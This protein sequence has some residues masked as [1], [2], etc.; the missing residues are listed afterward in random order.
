MAGGVVLASEATPFSHISGDNTA[1][2]ILVPLTNPLTIQPGTSSVI[3][4][5]ADVAPSIT[6]AFTFALANSTTAI[7]ATG[8]STGKDASYSSGSALPG[9]TQTISAMGITPTWTAFSGTDNAFAN[10]VGHVAGTLTLATN[11]SESDTVNQISVDA[12]TVANIRNM[13][14][15]D[16]NGNVLTNTITAPIASPNVLVFT[17]PLSVAKSSPVT[18]KVLVD[19]TPTAAGSSA[20]SLTGSGAGVTAYGATTGASIAEL[21]PVG[22]AQTVNIGSAVVSGQVTIAA[23]S[24]AN[25]GTTSTVQ[26]G[27]TS[28]K[29][30]AVTVTNASSEAV[31]FKKIRLVGTFSSGNNADLSNVRVVDGSGNVLG[32]VANLVAG[33]GATN[34]SLTTPLNIA[35]GKNAELAVLGDVTSSATAITQTIVVNVGDGNA[36]TGAVLGQQSGASVNVAAAAAVSGPTFTIN[37]TSVT[38]TKV[39]IANTNPLAAGGVEVGRF[40]LTNGGTVS[41]DITKIGLN[42]LLNTGGGYS[43]HTGP[44]DTSTTMTFM[45]VDDGTVLV[46][47]PPLAFVGGTQQ[48]T[49]GVGTKLR[50]TPGQTRIVTLIIAAKGAI[51]TGDASMLQ[52]DKATTLYDTAD[53]TKTNMSIDT[54]ATL[55][56]VSFK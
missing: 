10:E 11:T 56:S 6:G 55:D 51:G 5:Q 44:A 47:S 8:T 2:T 40:S 16:S 32:T 24:I 3:S 53:G 18:I 7:V 19:I 37:A 14:I 41:V 28:V 39:A 13:R 12:T 4:V 43:T 45:S 22:T 9:N 48:V 52:V 29:F 46:T 31:T 50:L 17:S 26:S 35:A 15:V 34:I 36:V 27:A 38:A 42:E 20:V 49:L 23:S 33:S 1:E 30:A 21:A 54:K 25:L